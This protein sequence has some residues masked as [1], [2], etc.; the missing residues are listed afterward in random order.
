VAYTTNLLRT[1]KFDFTGHDVYAVD[2]RARPMATRSD[3][4]AGTLAQQIRAEYLQEKL[5][6]KG[7]SRS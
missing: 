2:S 4:G 6:D 1:A 5:A 7:P 3:G